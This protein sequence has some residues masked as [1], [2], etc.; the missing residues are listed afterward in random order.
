MPLWTMPARPAAERARAAHLDA[1][2]IAPTHV[3]SAPATWSVIGEHIDHY[4]GVTIMGLAS[5][6]AA[7]AISPRTD[8]AIAVHLIDSTGQASED[9]TT[10]AELSELAAAQSPGVD[11]EGQP[12]LPPAPQGTIAVRLGGII[13][14][15]INRQMLSR[16]TA[17]MDITV[18]NDI[19]DNA[20]LGALSAADV[21]TALALLGEADDLNEAPM[22]ARVADVCSQ[23]VRTFAAHPPLRARHS[24]ALRGAGE[25]I[26][27][28]DYADGSVT[29]APH[30]VNKELAAFAVAVPG[31]FD[32]SEAITDIRQRE[33]FIDDACHAFGTESLRLL[34]DASPRVI[35]WLTAVHKV[36]GPEN[37]PTIQ[38]ASA[39]LAFYGHETER[40]KDLARALRSRRGADLFPLLNQSHSAL[41]TMYGF[42]SA[43]KLVQ[44][45]SLRGAVAARAAH[46]GTAH[47]MIAYVPAA[48]AENFAADLSAEGLLIVPLDAGETAS[49]DNA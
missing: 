36:Y 47:A 3:A 44:L 14:T 35:D 37:Q 5:P 16:E 40:A 2:G 17:G 7:A 12:I 41:S 22:R 46:A 32:A 31:E 25:T 23:A 13:H 45:A 42:A 20:G 18:V 33:R 4:G 34:P 39:W 29:Q 15:L 24:A 6:R 19:P 30:A 28:I 8:G 10:L 11:S 26:T 43:D 9:S 21:A 1:V 27:I 38:D 48:S 49:L